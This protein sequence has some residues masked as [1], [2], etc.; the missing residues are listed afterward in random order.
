[1]ACVSTVPTCSDAAT[2]CRMGEH[3]QTLF[4]GIVAHPEAPALACPG[5]RPDEQYRLLVE[6]NK[7]QFEVSQRPSASKLF[8]APVAPDP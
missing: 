1:M 6:W 7:N 2:V 5:V 8:E 4:E 3:L